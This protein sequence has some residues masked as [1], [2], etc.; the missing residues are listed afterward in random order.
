M[1]SKR[2]AVLGA[3]AALACALAAPT[4]TA[5]R[6]ACM[7]GIY[8]DANL[9]YGNPDATFRM[10]SQLRTKVVRLNLHWGGRF[11]V[12]GVD[13]TVRPTDPN[14]G[15]YDWSL[16]DRA[17][18]YAAQYK[19]QVVFS[20]VG[21]PALGERRQGPA[22]RA[23]GELHEPAA[24]L[25]LRGR[26][27]LQRP[28]RRAFRTAASCPPS[29]TGSRG[30]SRTT[31]SGCRRSTA[32][33]TIV[34]RRRTTRRSATRSSRA[35]RATLIRGE[36]VACGVTAPRGNNA[37]QLEPRPSVSP[38]AF[39]RGDE[40][41]RRDAASTPT[42]TIRTTAAR[43]RSRRRRRRAGKTADRGHA[44]EHRRAR[45][46][47][48]PP[49]RQARPALDHRV[50]LPDARPTASSASRTR[51]R[52]RTCARRTGSRKRTR[53]STCSSGSCSR[54][55]RTSAAGSPAS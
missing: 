33:R 11:G 5:S 14:D 12:A 6:D 51:S 3:L 32:A 43:A 31:R 38:L 1:P 41:L 29:S 16:Y 17:V 46:G 48:Q 22:R 35:S 25:R 47:A 4:A 53:G 26:D 10:L 21:T 50:R 54:T 27:A 55:T 40:A 52:P 9:L 28:Y 30:T 7:K 34:E 44:R 49:L 45:G 15:Q 42:R 8:D 24:R 13:P 19:I 39:L 36:K 23:D 18:L 2:I 20:I 37:P